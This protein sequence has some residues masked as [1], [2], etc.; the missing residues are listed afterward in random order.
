MVNERT[1]RMRVKEA[2][3]SGCRI[4]TRAWNYK[5]QWV[6]CRV[7]NG[8]IVCATA[9]S[10]EL[11]VQRWALTF[12]GAAVCER[13]E[14][15]PAAARRSRAIATRSPSDTPSTSIFSFSL[16]SKFIHFCFLLCYRTQGI[17]KQNI[18]CY[19]WK[20]S[21]SNFYHKCASFRNLIRHSSYK[22]NR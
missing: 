4:R 7:C 15:R 5:W 13:W 16:F 22:W 17:V 10:S 12:G 21:S 3:E 6:Y 18:I 9:S 19:S 1:R 8:V 11:T 14:R 20:I 2:A